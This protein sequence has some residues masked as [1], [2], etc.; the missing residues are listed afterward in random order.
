LVE[1]TEQLF[2]QAVVVKGGMIAG[3]FY[4]PVAPFKNFLNG[5]QIMMR[6]IEGF[7][8][9]GTAGKV[10]HHIILGRLKGRISKH[11]EEWKKD[12]EEVR[13][14]TTEIQRVKIT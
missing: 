6:G 13:I 11:D 7:W 3:L 10:I 8:T 1:I 4:N 14:R 9:E 12:C 5:M 2:V